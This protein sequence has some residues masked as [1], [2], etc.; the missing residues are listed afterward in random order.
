MKKHLFRRSPFTDL[1]GSISRSQSRL[2]VV[3][4]S[5]RQPVYESPYEG[6]HK[7]VYNSKLDENFDMYW[8]DG[9]NQEPIV[10]TDY[11]KKS[12]EDLKLEFW[13]FLGWALAFIAFKR[14][15]IDPYYPVHEALY[16]AQKHTKYEK[17][18]YKKQVEERKELAEKYGIKY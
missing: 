2:K 18:F 15:F 13:Y 10:D 9:T 3:E 4:Y 5:Q 7:I 8:Y 11:Q 16:D 12:K 6:E 17:E 14:N 1:V